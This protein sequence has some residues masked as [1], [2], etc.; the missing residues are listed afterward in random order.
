MIG[1]EYYT[2]DGKDLIRLH[3][4]KYYGV[5]NKNIDIV[6]NPPVCIDKPIG[7]NNPFSCGGISD[8][9]V[10][11]VSDDGLLDLLNP[12]NASKIMQDISQEFVCIVNEMLACS[13][14]SYDYSVKK[15]TKTKNKI[16]TA[17]GE[18]GMPFF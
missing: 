3:I 4:G 15:L 12:E 13:N 14:R 17:G 6:L 9:L 16:I 11:D 18:Y 8:T 5:K 1:A 10:S 2:S 7:I